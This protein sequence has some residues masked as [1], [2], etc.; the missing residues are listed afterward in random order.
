MVFAQT[1]ICP[2]KWGALN[3][4][5]YRD[6]NGLTN[7][8]QKTRSGVYQQEEKNLP[9]SEV[10]RSGESQNENGKKMIDKDLDLARELKVLSKIEA[11]R[12]KKDL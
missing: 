2:R 8:V 1:R 6:T 12:E 4:L 9:S 7:L 3:S 10:C 11:K 5:G